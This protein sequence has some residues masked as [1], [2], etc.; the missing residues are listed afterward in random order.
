MFGH[1]IISCKLAWYKE[2]KSRFAGAEQ[3]GIFYTSSRNRLEEIV[4]RTYDLQAGS[5][6]TKI[7]SAPMTTSAEL[8]VPSSSLTVPL[9]GSTWT[10]LEEVCSFAGAPMPSE[11]V[12]SFLSCSCR[13]TRWLSSQGCCHRF[14]DSTRSMSL[15]TLPVSDISTRCCIGVAPNVSANMPHL[16]SMPFEFGARCTAAPTSLANRDCS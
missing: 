9:P 5:K 16:R 7:P 10:T 6:R 13:F 15:I 12:A 2:T 1:R 4:S 3:L 8:V 14:R 11:P